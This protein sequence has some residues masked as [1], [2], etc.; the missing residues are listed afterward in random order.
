MFKKILSSN[1]IILME[2]IVYMSYFGYDLF[3]IVYEPSENPIRY[4][5]KAIINEIIHDLPTSI[6]SFF[7]TEDYNLFLYSSSQNLMEI[8][9]R[10]KGTKS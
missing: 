5:D 1:K 10:E 2:S 4:F 8:G 6:T 7:K 3:M 9:A